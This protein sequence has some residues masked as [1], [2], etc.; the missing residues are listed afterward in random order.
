MQQLDYTELPPLSTFGYCNYCE[1]FSDG[2]FS[3]DDGGLCC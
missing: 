2:G 3:D 1:G